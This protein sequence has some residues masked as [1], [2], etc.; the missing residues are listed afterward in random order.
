MA[1][2]LLNKNNDDWL[3]DYEGQL[4]IDA[5]ET[6]DSLVITAPIA[7]VS[8]NNLDVSITDETVTIKGDR[9]DA[10]QSTAN[11]FYVQE[12]YWGAFSRT[13]QIPIPVD[14][15]N[16]QAILKDGILNIVIPKLKKNRSKSL[17]IQTE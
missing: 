8:E 15:D 5:Y 14:S 4:A 17:K 1:K 16:A 9:T 3:E 10:R 2:N 12:C 6:E 7:G 13:F 11:G